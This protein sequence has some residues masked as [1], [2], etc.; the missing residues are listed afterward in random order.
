MDLTDKD[1]TLNSLRTR[2]LY[3]A[4]ISLQSVTTKA[5]IHGP[6]PERIRVSAEHEYGG[7]SVVSWIMAIRRHYES[8]TSC[9]EHKV[10]TV[11]TPNQ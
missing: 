9:A 3:S 2:C 11:V 10:K 7:F 8:L 1:V 4:T 5:S 6:T